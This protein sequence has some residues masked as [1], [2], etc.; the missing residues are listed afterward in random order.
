MDGPLNTSLS[1]VDIQKYNY[2]TNEIWM[3]K[4][5]NMIDE[6]CHKSFIER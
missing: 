4:T 2:W 3:K 1:T 6:K 5:G